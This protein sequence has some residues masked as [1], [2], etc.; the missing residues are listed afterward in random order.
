MKKK[1]AY[2]L[3]EL[4]CAM[5]ILCTTAA[6]ISGA[7]SKQM[8]ITG[9]TLQQL[10]LH[11]FIR[12]KIFE[13]E[14]QLKRNPEAWGKMKELSGDVPETPL[15]WDLKLKACEKHPSLLQADIRITGLKNDRSVSLTLF[16]ELPEVSKEGSKGSLPS[17]GDFS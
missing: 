10:S 15:K 16:M 3:F 1:N 17:E 2:L 9:V 5:I 12:E 8:E 11:P 13:I 6:A 4:L 14:K 7:F